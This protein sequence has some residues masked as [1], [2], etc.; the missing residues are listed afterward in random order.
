MIVGLDLNSILAESIKLRTMTAQD[1][2]KEV[3]KIAQYI[4]ESL[5]MTVENRRNTRT[6]FMCFKYGFF[7]L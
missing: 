7:D 6:L 5:D 1:R 3:Q 4:E 2:K